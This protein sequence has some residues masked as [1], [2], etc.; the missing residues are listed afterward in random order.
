MQAPIYLDHNAST[1]PASSVIAAMAESMEKNFANPSSVD[2]LAGAAASSAVEAARVKIASAIG[3]RPAD[4]IFT[5]GATEANNLAIRGTFLSQMLSGR[6]RIV[7][8]ATEHPSV[9][10]T[11]RSLEVL[12]ALPVILP[13]DDLGRIDLDQLKDAV[14]SDTALVSIMGANN[15]T[16]V[17]HPIEEIG[18]ICEEKGVSFHSDLT[19]LAGYASLKLEKSPLR[20]ASL[21]AHKM[22]GPKGI[23]ILY[24]RS[25]RPRAQ[26]VPVQTGGGHERGARSGTLNTEGAVAFAEAFRIRSK[27][28]DSVATL[29]GRRDRLQAM[30]L[31]IK[32]ARANG[33]QDHRLPHTINLS[34]D[35]IDPHALQHALRAD[36]IFSTSS[37]CSTEKVSISPVL[38]AMFGDTP[39]ARQGFRLGLGYGTTDAEVEQ[40]G[41]LFASAVDKLRNGV[42]GNQA[43]VVSTQSW[44]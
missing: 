22:Y 41:R 29:Q 5:S 11:V 4:I 17:L 6:A 34:I 15:E 37:A 27:S 16:G 38:S 40:V 3:A 35:G 2:H 43:D 24:A 30:L 39:R 25:R 36:V 44:A 7:T 13:V 20:L 31:E 10:E 12:G 21:S 18:K 33:D 32:G 42:F 26:L 28:L 8:V 9:L 19:Q 14:S 1:P 23:G